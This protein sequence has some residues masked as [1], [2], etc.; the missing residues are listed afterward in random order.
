MGDV[1]ECSTI[2]D[3]DRRVW[4]DIGEA[5]EVEVVADVKYKRLV[6]VDLWI[7]NLVSG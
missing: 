2:V 7:Q 5:G 3:V 1:Y 6:V 4:L